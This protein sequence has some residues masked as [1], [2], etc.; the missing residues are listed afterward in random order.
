MQR[1]IEYVS[2][3]TEQRPMIWKIIDISTITLTRIDFWTDTKALH[4]LTNK[5]DI[6]DLRNGAFCLKKKS[7]IR[8]QSIIFPRHDDWVSLQYYF[9]FSWGKFELIDGEIVDQNQ[10]FNAEFISKGLL[11][12]LKC[13][14]NFSRRR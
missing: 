11:N 13:Y 12:Y 14:R 7:L 3:T 10:G 2:S 8:I 4:A 9:L 6:G 5:T 1:M